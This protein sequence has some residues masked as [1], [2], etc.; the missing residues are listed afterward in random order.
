[1]GTMPD[2]HST[3]PLLSSTN[4]GTSTTSRTMSTGVR[5][6][7]TY[8]DGLGRAVKLE[9]GDGGGT[10]SMVETVY[11]ACACSPLGKVT[12][13]PGCSKR[14]SIEVSQHPRVPGKS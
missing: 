2:T 1:M 13:I 10:K 11:E 8:T 9:S 4:W 6:A 12:R 14:A 7:K 5:W 3:T